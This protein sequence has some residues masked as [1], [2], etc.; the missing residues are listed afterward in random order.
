M[1]CARA[2]GSGCGCVWRDCCMH[3]Q[4]CGCACVVVVPCRVLQVCDR[5]LCWFLLQWNKSPLHQVRDRDRGSDMAACT[6]GSSLSSTWISTTC[7]SLTCRDKAA[8]H[9]KWHPGWSPKQCCKSNP[10]ISLQ[11]ASPTPEDNRCLPT[12]QNF[13]L[14]CPPPLDCCCGPNCPT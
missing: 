1:L 12:L 11:N 2:P 4:R 7:H 14:P 10:K 5:T 13:S 6:R 8:L 3:L 9:T